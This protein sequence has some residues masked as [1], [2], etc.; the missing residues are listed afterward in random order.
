M[1]CMGALRGLLWPWTRALRARPQSGEA[2]CVSTWLGE[3]CARGSKFGQDAAPCQTSKTRMCARLEIRTGR[4]ASRRARAVRAKCRLAG[5]TTPHLSHARVYSVLTL[6]RA[7]HARPPEV[8]EKLVCSRARSV[9]KHLVR[10]IV[11]RRAR[12]VRAKCRLAGLTVDNPEK[13][14]AKNCFFEVTWSVRGKLVQE[15]QLLLRVM[16]LGWVSG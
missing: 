14:K 8:P 4:L 1:T 13:S 9:R 7:P 10:W 6:T 3:A 5:L 12:T 16:V 2:A 15:L 11:S